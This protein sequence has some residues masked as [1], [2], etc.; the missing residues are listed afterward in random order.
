MK[1]KF[2]AKII[3]TTDSEHPDTFKEE[4][5]DFKD[6]YIIDDN[7]FDDDEDI[8]RYIK[9]D[10]KLVAGG[11]YNTEHIHDVEFQITEV[12]NGN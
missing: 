4:R 9:Y 11:G 7:F 3:Y 10:L 12:R 8:I 1:R 5:T 6:V 2:N